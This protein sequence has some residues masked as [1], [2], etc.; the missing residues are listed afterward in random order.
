[1]ANKY[2]SLYKAVEFIGRLIPKKSKV[3]TA[4][5][6][7]INLVIYFLMELDNI[8]AKNW[9]VTLSIHAADGLYLFYNLQQQF[10]LKPTQKYL[11]LHIFEENDLLKAINSGEKL[12]QNAEKKEYALGLWKIKSE[13]ELEW[14]LAYIKKV[15]FPTNESKKNDNRHSRNIPGYVRQAV[16][17][18]YEN[19]GR[20]CN[21]VQGKTPRHR[22][23]RDSPIEYDHILPYSRGGSSAFNNVQILCLEC[24]RIKSAT[25]R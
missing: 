22:V 3:T 25:A 20:Y 19:N 11:L 13:K 9:S 4:S 21:G 17:E 7:Y 23:D 10:F 2:G 14:L 1:M 5:Q 24:N 12:F 18:E 8:Q 15:Y 16:L 6:K